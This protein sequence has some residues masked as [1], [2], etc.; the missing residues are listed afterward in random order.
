MA[1]IPQHGELATQ[2][3]ITGR[4]VEMAGSIERAAGGGFTVHGQ[5]FSCHAA[6]MGEA[7]ELLHDEPELEIGE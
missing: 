4:V 5:G 7:F 2:E 1:A 6:T 3:V